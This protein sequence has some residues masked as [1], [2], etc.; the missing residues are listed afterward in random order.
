MAETKT[1]ID[2]KDIGRTVG[3]ITKPPQSPLAQRENLGFSRMADVLPSIPSE[4][5]K[6]P[7]NTP[8]IIKKSPYAELYCDCIRANWSVGRLEKLAREQC[9]ESISHGT[10][11]RLQKLI[12]STEKVPESYVRTTLQGIETEH[13]DTLQELRNLVR[14]LIDRVTKLSNREIPL[15]SPDGKISMNVA[16][17]TSEAISSLT[18]AITKLAQVEAVVG[19][20]QRGSGVIDV[21]PTDAD[22]ARDEREIRRVIKEFTPEQLALYRQASRILRRIHYLEGEFFSE[23][24]V[25]DA[26]EMV[27][28][29]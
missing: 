24:S 19:R 18:T 4:F 23:V 15:I 27:L 17:G 6:V 29:W 9:G 13:L 12:L 8:P 25:A 26:A 16:P 21:S 28:T 2:P 14:F 10:F 5:Q 11:H 3:Q 7:E 22:P 1:P 20:L